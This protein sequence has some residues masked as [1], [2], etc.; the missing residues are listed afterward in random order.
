MPRFSTLGSRAKEDRIFVI[1]CRSWFWKNKTREKGEDYYTRTYMVVLARRRLVYRI[2]NIIRIFYDRLERERSRAKMNTREIYLAM[3][4]WR[5]TDRCA[6]RAERSAEPP[7]VASPSV[8]FLV[9]SLQHER[10]RKKYSRRILIP[11]FSRIRIHTRALFSLF[12]RPK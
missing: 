10:R 1:V 4:I 8:P 12:I 9:L 3:V 6:R 5:R 7:V 2:A 11:G